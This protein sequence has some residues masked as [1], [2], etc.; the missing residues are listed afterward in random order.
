MRVRPSQSFVLSL[1]AGPTSPFPDFSLLYDVHDL[2]MT[3]FTL[4][5]PKGWE[6]DLHSVRSPLVAIIERQKP[7]PLRN[8]GLLCLYWV[9][10]DVQHTMVLIA[11][12]SRL[13]VRGILIL[14]EFLL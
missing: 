12:D 9:F 1:P 3:D 14:T 4:V 8:I 6:Y 10:P 13:P 2:L 7:T 11:L 5:D